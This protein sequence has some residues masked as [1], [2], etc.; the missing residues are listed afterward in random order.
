MEL[1]KKKELQYAL[2]SLQNIVVEVISK[3]MTETEWEE[4]DLV[5]P[6]E[7][8]DLIN[9]SISHTLDY[10][11]KHQELQLQETELKEVVI[12]Y[13]EP[14]VEQLLNEFIGNDK[15]GYKKTK[16]EE[17]LDKYH[18]QEKARKDLEKYLHDIVQELGLETLGTYHNVWITDYFDDDPISKTLVKI[19]ININGNYY[20]VETK[21][22]LYIPVTREYLLDFLTQ[23]RIN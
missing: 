20:E 16:V 9:D 14:K 8:D 13:V 15:K 2:Q 7:L 10:L 11:A 3:T 6:E 12:E 18:K 23:T 22:E 21:D 1:D 19:N 4:L 5:A 17:F